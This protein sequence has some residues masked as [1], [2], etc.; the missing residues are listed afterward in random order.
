MKRVFNFKDKVS[1]EE[2]ISSLKKSLEYNGEAMEYI[3]EKKRV[4]NDLIKY[5]DF[6][7]DKEELANIEYIEFVLNFVGNQ[8][9]DNLKK[10]G[11]YSW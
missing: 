2:L 6:E 4:V 5:R 1:E 3:L 11:V 10:L 7:Q 8:Y 9:S